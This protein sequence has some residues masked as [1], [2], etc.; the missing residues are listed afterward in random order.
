MEEHYEGEIPKEQSPFRN[1]FLARGYYTG[2]NKWWMYVMGGILAFLG[3]IL[4]QFIMLVPLL[5]AASQHGIGM[6]EI[7][8]DP[9]ILFNPDAIG[10]NR[11]VMLSL[12]MG[13]FVF[14]LIALL[15]AVKFIHKKT[16]AS[17]ITGF[18]K[19]RWRRYFFSFAIW[20]SLLV[21]LG[22]A[23]YLTSPGDMELK[24]DLPKFMVLLVVAVIF[25]PIQTATEEIL[26]RGYLMQG[27]GQ[28]TKSGI[29]PLIITSVLFGLMHGSNPEAKA[30]G[31]LIML[32]YYM[33][34]GLFLGFLTLLDEG[35]ELAMGIHCANNL[36]SSLT[37]TSK[38]S[39][40]QT[41]AIFYAKTEDPGGEFVTWLIMA[42]V[43]FAILYL[44]YRWK[45]WSV[46]LK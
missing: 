14:T 40:L 45:N 3:Y 43:C 33:M 39:V 18:E 32:P 28:M 46:V 31:L 27:L 8:K 13:M 12:M 17:V 36:V 15:L 30:H 6:A 25:V 4:F 10:M 44:K 38:N 7:S 34:F 41:D 2:L 42:A 9:Y 16:V 19:I 5:A 35:L 26:F 37:V 1:L 23:S 20:G 29:I 11:S 24:F 22:I 21:I